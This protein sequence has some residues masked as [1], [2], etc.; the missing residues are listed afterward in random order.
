MISEREINEAKK[1]KKQSLVSLALGA[2][3]ILPLL[4]GDSI[5]YNFTQEVRETYDFVAEVLAVASSAFFVY[6]IMGYLG[7][8]KITNSD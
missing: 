1:I 4:M 3:C 5:S 7:N 8:Y 6:G 2:S